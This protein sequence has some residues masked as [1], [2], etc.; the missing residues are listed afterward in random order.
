MKYF[1]DCVL[2]GER[3][4]PDSEEGYADVRVLEG[5][6]KALQT[7]QSVTLPPFQRY[8]RIE[9]EQQEMKLGAVSTPELV[10]ASNP[11][12]GEEKKPKN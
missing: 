11:G 9:T 1:S 5:I 7:G 2:S 4:E 3:P 12:R 6:L 8:H 10:H